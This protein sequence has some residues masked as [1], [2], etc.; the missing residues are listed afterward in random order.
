[1]MKN[2]KQNI[3]TPIILFW[4]LPS[5]SMLETYKEK[6]SQLNQAINRV[7]GVEIVTV[8][9]VI[10]KLTEVGKDSGRYFGVENMKGQISKILL[11]VNE[12]KKI[13]LL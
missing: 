7:K 11:N 9:D 10:L 1:M 6:C 12:I 8:K 2:H 3:N 13:T 4:S 5:I